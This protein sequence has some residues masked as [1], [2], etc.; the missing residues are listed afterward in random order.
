MLSD[1]VRLVEGKFG[2]QKEWRLK[3]RWRQRSSADDRTFSWYFCCIRLLR[4]DF[5]LC[6]IIIFYL[7]YLFKFMYNAYTFAWYLQISGH[8]RRSHHHRHVAIKLITIKPNNVLLTTLLNVLIINTDD[9]W[10]HSEIAFAHNTWLFNF[11]IRN[12]WRKNI[13]CSRMFH[14]VLFV[15]TLTQLT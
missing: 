2:L 7:R 4:Y 9:N 15:L 13:E 6:S 5:C 11:H 14:C 3:N 1:L 8:R 10:R 12:V